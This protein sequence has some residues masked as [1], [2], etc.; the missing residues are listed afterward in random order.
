MRSRLDV[1]MFP[2]VNAGSWDEGGKLG[3]GIGTRAIKDYKSTAYLYICAVSSHFLADGTERW[4]KR[5][6]F[7]PFSQLL[8]WREG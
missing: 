3:A 2:H 8:D 7:R 6:L 4:C 1:M 5:Q